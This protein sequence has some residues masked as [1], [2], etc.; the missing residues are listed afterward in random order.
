M[1]ALPQ[2][3][4][5]G[6]RRWFEPAVEEVARLIREGDPTVGWVGDDRLGLYLCTDGP[7][8]GSWELVR[9][10]EDGSPEHIVAR[11]KPGVDIRTLPAHLAYHDM[12]RK[13][14]EEDLER[15]ALVAEAAQ[16]AQQAADVTVAVD[17]F[18]VSATRRSRPAP[19]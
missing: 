4:R 14:A 5:A 19:A 7:Y 3:T 10:P 8:A 15:D 2:Y 6:A 9:W 18:L 16:K 17:D 1:F 11:S 13:G 12:R